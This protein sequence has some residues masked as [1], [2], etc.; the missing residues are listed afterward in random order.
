MKETLKKLME[1]CVQ[2]FELHSFS[3]SRIDRYKFLWQKKLMPFMEMRS[4]PYYDASVGQKFIRSKITGGI[5]T[6]YERDIIRSIYFLSEF[7][8]KGTVSKRQGK[9]AKRE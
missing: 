1:R 3:V 2:Y 6:P 8:E 7:Q 9:A 5:I 4:I